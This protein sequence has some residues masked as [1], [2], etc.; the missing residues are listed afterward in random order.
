MM[1]LGG[2]AI[3]A[4]QETAALTVMAIKPENGETL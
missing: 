1:T 3:P 2:W 4:A